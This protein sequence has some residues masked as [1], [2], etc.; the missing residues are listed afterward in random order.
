MHRLAAVVDDLRLYH[1]DT[2]TWSS[3]SSDFF[4]EVW[5]FFALISEPIIEPLS[6]LS[7]SLVLI[8]GIIAYK[9]SHCGKRFSELFLVNFSVTVPVKLLDQGVCDL[10]AALFILI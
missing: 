10:V 2:H 8:K 3:I 7:K 5:V 4:R 9:V 6:H 1:F